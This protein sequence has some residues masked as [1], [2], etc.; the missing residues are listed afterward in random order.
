MR[1]RNRI[2]DWARLPNQ[3]VALLSVAIIVARDL[4]TRASHA[5]FYLSFIKGF[6]NARARCHQSE[7]LWL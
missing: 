2:R 1:S 7:T 4:E 5:R 6:N 3:S